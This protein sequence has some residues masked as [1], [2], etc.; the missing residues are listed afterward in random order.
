MRSLILTFN[1]NPDMA[2]KKIPAILTSLALTTSTLC[3]TDSNQVKVQATLAIRDGSLLKTEF[4][5]KAVS[6]R[7]A[8]TDELTLH[9]VNLRSVTF[10][11]TNGT[12]KIELINNDRFSMQ[13][14]DETFKVRSSLGEFN[15][16]RS[17]I[18]SLTFRAVASL[19][20]NAASTDG[21]VY[22]CSFDNGIDKPEVGPAGMLELGVI[23]PEGGRTGGALLVKPGV[24]GAQIR[25]PAG[26]FG[27]T[28]CIEFWANL[29]SGKTE[30]S[31]GGDPRFFLLSTADGNE[32]CHFE[33][34]SN[35]GCG[36]CGLTAHVTGVR[37]FS[38]EGCRGMM[39]Y[40]DIFNGKDFN[41][42][43]H[44]AL[45]WTKEC[46]TIYLDGK[47]C[48]RSYGI[49]QGDALAG[50]MVLDI[51]LN[52]TRGKSYNNKSAFLMDDL[53]IW[54]HAKAEFDVNP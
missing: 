43:H 24:A 23:R 41:G 31:T 14:A 52:R 33:Y 25:F 5:S 19:S 38:H 3:A 30:F 44:Y 29:Q 48:C 7:T 9:S 34:A 11:G 51:P 22:A 39:P 42:W 21:L 40:S 16:P 47:E 36:H 8:F 17:G 35:D 50:E 27:A 45:S 4:L 54:N 12:A 13:I 28:G 15:V 37:V 32:V 6:G 26:S 49:V 2:M 18:Q 1:A 10:D 53:K 46:A 20:A